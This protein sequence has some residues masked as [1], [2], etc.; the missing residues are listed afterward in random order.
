MDMTNIAMAESGSANKETTPSVTTMTIV[1][2][3][4]LGAGLLIAWI[5]GGL[6]GG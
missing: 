5:F 3:V 6:S 4:V 2:F 1:S